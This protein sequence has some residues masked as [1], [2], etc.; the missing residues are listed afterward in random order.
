MNR[1]ISGNIFRFI[2]QMVNVFVQMLS[3][4]EA[5]ESLSA[6]PADFFV[7]LE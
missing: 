7:I 3:V 6:L 1:N 2:S 5:G 4:G